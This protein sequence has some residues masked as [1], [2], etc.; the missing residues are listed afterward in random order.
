MRFWE[1]LRELLWVLGFH[2]VVNAIPRIAPRMPWNSE[3][4][5]S[6]IFLFTPRALLLLKSGWFPAFWYHCPTTKQ[7]GRHTKPNR[8]FCW[9][10]CWDHA[11]L[12]W[13]GKRPKAGN[14]Q[15]ME[16]QMEKREPP[17]GQG[18]KC[19]KIG[20]SG[21]FSIYYPLSG[22][23]WAMFAPSWG[24]FSILFSIL[25]PFPASGR[26]PCHASPAW[27]QLN[28]PIGWVGLSP[29]LRLRV[30]PK[31]RMDTPCLRS[32]VEISVSGTKVCRVKNGMKFGICSCKAS[33]EKWREICR[34]KFWVLSSFASWGKRNSKNSPEIS[35]HFSW[36]LPR[37]V[38]GENFTAALLQAL[39]S[40][41]VW[42]RGGRFLIKCFLGDIFYCKR[43]RKTSATKSMAFRGTLW[44]GSSQGKSCL[45]LSIHPPIWRSDRGLRG[46]KAFARGLS[47]HLVTSQELS[48]LKRLL[49]WSARAC[50]LNCGAFYNPCFSEEGLS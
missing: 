23:F 32:V 15:N 31:Y 5:F 45:E 41:S 29:F 12:V 48:V 39:Q 30:F 20:F 50:V 21:E 6:R 47:W 24:L 4:C 38:S 28:C 8:I 40:R 43:G 17:P 27:S 16:N 36:R 22:H 7:E 35:R 37:A 13:H 9:F 46:Q 42:I 11:G 1:S 14:G 3:S 33:G 49:L 2:E 18:Q 25:S 44:P 34:E 10:N 26:F 19:Q